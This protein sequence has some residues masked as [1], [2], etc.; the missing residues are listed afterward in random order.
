M[1]C[2]PVQHRS[3]SRLGKLGRQ[4]QLLEHP[5][6]NIQFHHPL[7]CG[8]VLVLQRLQGPC[9]E[10]YVDEHEVHI[11]SG[12]SHCIH[13]GFRFRIWGKL[14]R[15]WVFAEGEAGLGEAEGHVGC[16]G[17]HRKRA[18]ADK[19][20]RWDLQRLQG[21]AKPEG[22]ETNSISSHPEPWAR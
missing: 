22:R 18:L 3:D 10:Q 17:H 14:Q 20:V 16:V 11:D 6:R 5:V 21:P 15:T 1:L 2:L 13:G 9:D 4:R 8:A 7:A 19:F 12:S